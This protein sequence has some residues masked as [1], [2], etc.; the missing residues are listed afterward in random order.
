MDTHTPTHG[1]VKPTAWLVPHACAQ[2]YHP[3]SDTHGQQFRP[4]WGS[5]AHGKAVAA[6][7]SCFGLIGAHKHGIAV[8]TLYGQS[9]AD[10]PQ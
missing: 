5:S 3:G 4:Y 6:M 9:H 10:E 7:Y 8:G 2:P 1:F